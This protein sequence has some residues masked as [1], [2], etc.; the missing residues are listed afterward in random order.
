MRLLTT[1]QQTAIDDSAVH[2]VWLIRL[3]FSTPVYLNTSAITIPYD[4]HDWLAGQVINVDAITETDSAEATGFTLSLATN[5]EALIARALT[6]RTTNRRC[7]VWLALV[8]PVTGAIIDT[9]VLIEQGLCDQPT[10]SEDRSMAVAAISIETEMADFARPNVI[11]YTNSD[12]Q[13]RY[14]GD[15][16]FEYTGQMAERSVAFPSRDLML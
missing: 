4:G 8:N 14:P 1:D 5:S 11:R 10:I 9:P 6:E 7:D 15:R 3:D 16:I 13:Q 2:M 12:Q